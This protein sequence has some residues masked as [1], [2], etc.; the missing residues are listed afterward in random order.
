VTAHSFVDEPQRTAAVL[1]AMGGLLA[2]S[3][4]SSRAI[5]RRGLPVVIFFLLLGMLAGS[6]GIGGIDFEDY[7][8]T[9]HLGTVALALILFDGGLNTPIEVVKQRLAPAAMLATAGVAV[10]ASVVGLFGRLIGFSWTDALLLGAVVS[11]TDAAAVF[12]I[13]RELC[14]L[15]SR[16][17]TPCNWCASISRSRRS[18]IA[19]NV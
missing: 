8:L 9:F 5:A 3:V 12:S 11:S 15:A 2:L 18:A 6:E 1:T 19:R 14:H 13:L 16:T 17:L 4:L 7:R 10:T